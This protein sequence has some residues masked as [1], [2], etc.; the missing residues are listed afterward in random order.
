[1]PVASHQ[2]DSGSIPGQV[3]F[4]V[5]AFPQLQDKCQ[6]IQATFICLQM[7]MVS[8][9]RCSTWLLLNKIIPIPYC[10]QFQICWLHVIAMRAL[11]SSGIFQKAWRT[12]LKSLPEHRKQTCNST[13]QKVLMYG[14]ISY[15]TNNLAQSPLPIS[16]LLNSNPKC[17]DV[18]N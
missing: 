13:E 7:V 6:E 1:M 17:M 2:V 11:I 14:R 10:L 3:N 5:E 18:T 15:M 12:N 8:D 16:L 4:L 9:L